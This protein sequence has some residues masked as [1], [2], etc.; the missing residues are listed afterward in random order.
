MG[1]GPA[2]RLH[3]GW[4]GV[5]LAAL[6]LAA[7]AVLASRLELLFVTPLSALAVLPPIGFAYYVI[8][9][10]GVAFLNDLLGLDEKDDL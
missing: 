8:W 6:L 10:Y 5:L 7:G 2:R 1:V 9:R 3:I 4:H